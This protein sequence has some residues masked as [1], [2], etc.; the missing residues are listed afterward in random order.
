MRAG[1]QLQ[2]SSNWVRLFQHAHHN[3]CHDLERECLTFIVNNSKLVKKSK[4]FTDI[5]E[6]CLKLIATE[7][8]L[9]KKQKMEE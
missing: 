9:R 3:G 2:I 7:K 8:Q 6:E 5:D 1:W 4:G